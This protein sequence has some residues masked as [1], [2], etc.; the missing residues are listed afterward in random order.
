LDVWFLRYV[1][2]QTDMLITVLC[3]P[4]GV[5]VNIH[6]TDAKGWHLGD[7]GRMWR[8]TSGNKAG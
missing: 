7:L 4:T 1:T 2:G 8:A 3:P 6:F 5:E